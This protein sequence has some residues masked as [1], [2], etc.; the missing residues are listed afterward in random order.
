MRKVLVRLA[1]TFIFAAAFL[2]A[3]KHNFQVGKLVSVTD[4]EEL[5]NG[6]SFRRAIFTARI[7]DL[8][9]TAKGGLIHPHSGDIGQG[10][11]V[12]DDVQV[13]VEGEDLIFLRPDGKELKTK[14]IKRERVR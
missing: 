1:L 6:T 4:Q 5:Y 14:I 8:L 10:L 2:G 11:I 12:G 7:G 9:Y 13:A 3:T